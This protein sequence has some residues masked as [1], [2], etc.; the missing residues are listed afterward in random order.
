MQRQQQCGSRSSQ[1]VALSADRRMPSAAVSPGLQLLL[2]TLPR[3]IYVHWLPLV[4]WLV[5]VVLLLLLARRRCPI[6]LPLQ[7]KWIHRVKQLRWRGMAASRCAVGAAAGPSYRGRKRRASRL[8]LW[9]LRLLL[10]MPLEVLALQHGSLRTCCS[11]AARRP[12]RLL[13]QQQRDWLQRRLKCAGVGARQ[14]PPQQPPIQQLV[15]ACLWD[16]E[17]SNCSAQGWAAHVDSAYRAWARAKAAL[18]GHASQHLACFTQHC[19]PPITGLPAVAAAHL[20]Q[21][22]PLLQHI[23]SQ[24]LLLRREAAQL[25]ADGMP[26]LLSLDGVDRRWPAQW[27]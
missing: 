11:R 14:R 8:L 18:H 26:Q 23:L 9:L 2:L 25:R 10:R 17:E 4:L 19:C 6:L 16:H 12:H 15:L 20:R 22:P 7:Q 27:G 24:A 13:L 21:Q 3:P 1:G 5:V